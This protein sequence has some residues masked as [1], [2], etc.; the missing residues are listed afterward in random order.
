MRSAVLSGRR[1]SAE[2]RGE[3]MPRREKHDG[4]ERYARMARLLAGDAQPAWQ[5]D[6]TRD[7]AM[8]DSS[9]SKLETEAFVYEK[10]IKALKPKREF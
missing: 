9:A 4:A 2:G 7:A 10:P 3:M 1:V 5:F 8:V 6:V